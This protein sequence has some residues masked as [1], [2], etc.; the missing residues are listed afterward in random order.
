MVGAAALALEGLP[1]RRAPVRVAWSS[2]RP[3]SATWRTSPCGC[4]RPCATPTS[5]PA[6]T[7]AAPASCSIATGS[8]E[9]R[10][11]PRAQRVRT[12]ARARR[13]D[14]RRET[15]RARVRRRDAARVRPGL[16]ARPRLRRRRPRGRGPAGPVGRA[17]GA[18]RQRAAVGPLAVRRLPAAQAG[19]LAPV[20]APP[21]TVVAF[22]SPGASPPRWPRS[23]SST[24]S[25]RSPSAGS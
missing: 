11:L 22:E 1:S 23:R 9:A 8:R 25:G 15:R 2:A 4:W 6:R 12:F 24:R 20:F 16:R 3:R 14:A 17:R 7:P 19:E 21:E 18:R 5:S 10:Q 13:A